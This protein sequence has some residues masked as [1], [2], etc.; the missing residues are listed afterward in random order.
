MYFKHKL[1][2]GDPSHIPHLMRLLSEKSCQDRFFAQFEPHQLEALQPA[3]AVGMPKAVLDEDTRRRVDQERRRI[4]YRDHADELR[5][6]FRRLRPRSKLKHAM[7]DDKIS[8]MQVR[9]TQ[10]LAVTIGRHGAKD[11]E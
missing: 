8:S 6:C 2:R 9:I 7:H 3:G 10:H 4:R 5:L 11:N 1:Y